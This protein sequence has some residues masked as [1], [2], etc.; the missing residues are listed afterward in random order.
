MTDDKIKARW[1]EMTADLAS[2][3]KWDAELDGNLHR[4]FRIGFRAGSAHA[5]GRCVFL[6]LVLVAACFGW[7][8][9][10]SLFK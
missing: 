3:R 6:S 9:A 4:M 1:D 7:I 10:S 8:A 5:Y 2:V